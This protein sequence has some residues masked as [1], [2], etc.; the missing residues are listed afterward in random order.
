M[1]GLHLAFLLFFFTSALPQ[2]HAAQATSKIG[3]LG[4]GIVAGQVSLY[5][6]PLSG[7]TVRLVPERMSVS[8][9]PR[10]QRQAVTD[11]QGR[12]RIT[13]VVAGSYYVS[14]LPDEYIITGPTADLQRK[15]V[16]ISEGEKIEG[17]DLVLKRGGVITGRVT[18]SNGRPIIRQ[19]IELT[20]IGEDGKPQPHLF[21]HPGMNL[22]DKQGAYRLTRVPEGRYLVSAGTSLSE[23][24]GML[25]SGNTYYQQ[26]FHPNVSDP[27]QAPVVEVSEGTEITGIDIFITEARKTFDIKGHVVKA[28]T[29]EPAEGIEIFY[30]LAREG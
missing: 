29:G 7:I 6:E 18:D 13:G 24:M 22:T 17:F 20:R 3:K 30:W 26:T 19:P 16:N 28:E 25:I 23:R 5:G 11:A 21:N 8:G 12:Y 2:T 4:M 14:L 1:P 27:S 10:S 15:M 9:D